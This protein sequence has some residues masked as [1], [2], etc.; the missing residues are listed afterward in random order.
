MRLKRAI[1][2]T[3]IMLLM[4]V[5]IPVNVRAEEDTTRYSFGHFYY[6]SHNGYVSICG[7][8]G[9]ETEVEIPS[10][11]SGR[12][13]SEI[14]SG[15]FRGCHTIETITVPD[16][17]V[18][19]YEDSFTGADSLTKII[20]HTVGVELHADSGV[21][22]EYVDERNQQ[23]TEETT[24]SEPVDPSEA[25]SSEPVSPSGETTSSEETTPS[26]G[27]A[28][29]ND[30]LEITTPSDTYP[31]EGTVSGI[32]E[33]AHEEFDTKREEALTEE[34]G[35]ASDNA[36]DDTGVKVTVTDEEV[37]LVDAYEETDDNESNYT[38]ILWIAA[39]LGIVIAAAAAGYLIKTKRNKKES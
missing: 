35:I 29:G 3:L 11:L 24:P 14:E 30:K 16:T 12:P 20:S 10:V 36:A 34:P 22:I 1:L 19:V 32:G 17:V 33:G 39:I 4:I 5:M 18:M 26:N 28:G 21:T 9:R 37:L 7:Y 6:H 27:S 38:V 23:S 31:E 8:L 2:C 15:S 25:M 13:V